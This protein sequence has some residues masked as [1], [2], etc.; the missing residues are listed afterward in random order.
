MNSVLKD[1]GQKSSIRQLYKMGS[2]TTTNRKKQKVQ[3]VQKKTTK[4]LLIQAV[5]KRQIDL[6]LGLNLISTLVSTPLDN[7]QRGY[8]FVQKSKSV[9]DC[10]IALENLKCLLFFKDRANQKI[11]S[12]ITSQ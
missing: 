7:V 11:R 12:S 6:G 8:S 1:S 3:A 4:S 9:L 5:F 2:K 10:E